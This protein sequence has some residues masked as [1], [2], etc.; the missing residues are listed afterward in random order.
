MVLPDL[1]RGE[2][3]A[4]TAKVGALA[5]TL[6]VKGTIGDRPW[7]VTLPLAGAAEGQGLSQLWARRKITDAEVAK[8]LGKLTPSEADARILAL[9]PPPSGDAAHEPRCA[10]KTPSRPGRP[11]RAELPLNLP[12]GWDFDKVF[13]GEH[14]GAATRRADA[15]TLREAL[16]YASAV[17]V[18]RAR[19]RRRF[20]VRISPAAQ[21]K[22]DGSHPSLPVVRARSPVVRLRARA[23]SRGGRGPNASLRRAD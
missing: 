1:Y 11:S 6:D 15:E 7:I 9:A 3:V 4:L 10:D 2:P 21:L 17:T 20:R 8:T 14:A 12:A 22:A 13:G 16:A 23:S 19:S 5:G 18:A